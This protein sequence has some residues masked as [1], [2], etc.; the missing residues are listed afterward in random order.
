MSTD[1]HAEGSTPA[2]A[3]RAVDAD[4]PA[5]AGQAGHADE[6]PPA[7]AH[8]LETLEIHLRDERMLA[9]HTVAAYLSDARQ[10]AGFCAGHA[11]DDPD[12]V[13]PLVL[14]RYLAALAGA[15]YARASMA[16]KVASVRTLF[17]ELAKRGLTTGDPGTA[18]TGPTPDRRLPR[19][20]RP[21]QVAALLA[22]P[23]ASTPVGQ[24]DRALLELCYASGARVSEL[25]GLDVDDVD[26]AGA[27]ARLHGKGDKDRLVPLGEPACEA[28]DRWLSRG[29]PALCAEVSEPDPRALF[30]GVRGGRLSDRGARAVVERTAVAAGLGR[31]S[32][33]TLRHSYATHL[34]EGGA[35]L[36]SVQELLGHVVLSTTQTYTHLS[37]QH[38]RSSYEGAHPRA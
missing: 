7:W 26:L 25:V 18:L 31:I 15:G 24:R 1:G 28:V 30:L 3:G 2:P 20:L 11:I 13:A 35:D 38:L 19:V 21:R 6:L 32:P 4:R 10:L 34:L 27:G 29:R 14:R 23:D 36:R 16:R 22:A 8:A 5:P 37:R 12:E 33:H 17:A 9:S